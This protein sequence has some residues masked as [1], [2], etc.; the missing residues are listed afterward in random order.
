MKG[1]SAIIR[2]VLKWKGH[3][4]SVLQGRDGAMTSMI[5]DIL[6]DFLDE[7]A[8]PPHRSAKCKRKRH[9]R[10]DPMQSS[11]YINYIMRP[12]PDQYKWAKLFLRRF[13]MPHSAVIEL[14]SESES[15]AMFS[16]WHSGSCDA[17]GRKRLVF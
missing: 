10:I 15:D 13:S 5:E 12:T 8:K 6:L 16:R 9:S 11:W 14:L 1:V 3:H 7:D 17:S 4:M 2:D